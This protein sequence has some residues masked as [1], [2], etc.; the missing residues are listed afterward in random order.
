MTLASSDAVST[1]SS[2]PRSGKDVGSTSGGQS[3]REF[4]PDELE[5]C[6]EEQE[7]FGR[8]LR[9]SASLSGLN[10]LSNRMLNHLLSLARLS[11]IISSDLASP[12]QRNLNRTTL[13]DSR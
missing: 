12:K 5:E 3:L 13:L 1:V 10:R 9:E 6:G 2:T 8:K 7:Q 4:I 11:F